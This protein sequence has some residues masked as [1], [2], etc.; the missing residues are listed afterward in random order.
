VAQQHGDPTKFP[1]WIQAV[2][3]FL[4]ALFIVLHLRFPS[5]PIDTI[6]LALLVLLLA[7]LVLPHIK[8]F[9]LPGGAGAVL[10]S[11][12][13]DAEQSLVKADLPT[14]S[15]PTALDREQRG[16]SEQDPNL[17]LAGIRIEIE[18]LLRKIGKH[19]NF[20]FPHDIGVARMIVALKQRHALTPEVAS[21]LSD[22]LYV[23][24]R[25][26]HGAS[27]APDVASRA[28]DAGETLI[29]TL[30]DQLEIY[31]SMESKVDRP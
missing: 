25:A 21:A 15:K 26:V 9:T 2:W 16:I 12:V 14:T 31:R 27:I 20:V 28:M 29:A 8:S 3:I 13:E 5:M 23:C 7:G 10:R 4:S 18:K 22:V 1:F 30:Q 24:D 6:T 19:M 11:R 17:V